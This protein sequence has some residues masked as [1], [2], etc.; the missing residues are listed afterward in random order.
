MERKQ[1]PTEQI[2]LRKVRSEALLFNDV[3]L[4]REIR[5]PTV[6]IGGFI[7]IWINKTEVWVKKQEG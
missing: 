6:E 1:A 7:P 4:R 5:H 2:L 3:W